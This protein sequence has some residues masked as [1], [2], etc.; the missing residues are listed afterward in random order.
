MAV[1]TQIIATLAAASGG[2]I[3]ATQDRGQQ[4]GER[5]KNYLV[6][7]RSSY[8]ADYGL[9]LVP[10]PVPSN[11]YGVTVAIELAE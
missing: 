7:S 10:G 4:I 3:Y 1:S 9:S 6:I 2:K 8:S 11:Q 5:G